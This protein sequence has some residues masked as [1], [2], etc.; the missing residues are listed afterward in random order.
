ML[1]LG[2]TELFQQLGQIGFEQ[3]H[4]DLIKVVD[5]IKDLLDVRMEELSWKIKRLESLLW[6]YRRE[7]EAHEG[8]KTF[9]PLSL[10][11]LYDVQRKRAQ[12]KKYML[13]CHPILFPRKQ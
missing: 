1:T 7:C 6:V 9:S 13:K 4:P 8:K 3:W 2:V 11:T 12:R 5:A 10:V